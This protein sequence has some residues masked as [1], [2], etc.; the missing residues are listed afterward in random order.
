MLRR[1]VSSSQHVIAVSLVA[2]MFVA[3]K[4]CCG[5][6]RQHVSSPPL[7]VVINMLVAVSSL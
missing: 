2:N 5:Q 4:C 6:A 1:R 3:V 7:P